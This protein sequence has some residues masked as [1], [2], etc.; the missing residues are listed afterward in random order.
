MINYIEE[1]A[2]YE[3]ISEAIN[4]L[5][6]GKRHRKEVVYM[7]ENR[8]L[9]IRTVSTMIRHGTYKCDH[10]RNM[11]RREGGK[12]RNI[13][14]TGMYPDALIRHAVT[15]VIRRVVEPKFIDDVYC[16]IEG[17]GLSFGIKRMRNHIKESGYKYYLKEDI[18]KYFE[19]VDQS[20]L[21]RII[22]EES[23][24]DGQTL[25]IIKEML[26]LCRSGM[27]IGTY[28]CQLWAN[29]MLMRMDRYITKKYAGVIRYGRYCDNL[30]ILGDDVNLLHK[31][32]QDIKQFARILHLKLNPCELG[33]IDQGLRCMGVVLYHTH[34]RL[35]KR[36]KE[37]MRKS[38]NV[39]S[40][41]GWLKQT[42][43]KHLIRKVMYKKFS[44]FVD[45][46]EYITAF[47]GDK[48]ELSAVNGKCIIIK[49]CVIEKSRFSKRNGELRDRAK[50]AFF[51]PDDPE[52]ELV[53]FTSSQPILYY[54]RIFMANK[55]KYL[56]CEV[57][58][59]K[60]NRQYKFESN[61]N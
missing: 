9:V 41:F 18:H 54:C 11:L 28:D 20:V 35:G 27:A 45:I 57:K 29:V 30:Y 16:N 46:P 33:R 24:C 34:T 2:S 32:H 43:S 8:D 1:I 36:I 37:R 52:R 15:R 61:E 31:V 49:D 50:I 38:K 44:D 13:T 4:K 51:Y 10:A 6:K 14:F 47:T 25:G 7:N 22:Q 40:Y 55:D 19:S 58:V 26:S 39:A 21:L 23:D 56:P 42:N 5:C 12:L 59:T 3:N 48:V 53:V 17:R 60:I